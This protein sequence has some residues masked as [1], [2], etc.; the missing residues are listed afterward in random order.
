MGRLNHGNVLDE[1][2]ISGGR[3]LPLRPESA[4]VEGHRSQGQLLFATWA[5][6]CSDVD[7]LEPVVLLRDRENSEGENLRKTNPLLAHRG[8]ERSRDLRASRL[9][10]FEREEFPLREE[11]FTDRAYQPDQSSS[12]CRSPSTNR[13]LRSSNPMISDLVTLNRIALS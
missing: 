7:K 5:I 11:A 13:K 3:L 6:T 10:G 2:A 1:R 12:P 9:I 8:A 4:V